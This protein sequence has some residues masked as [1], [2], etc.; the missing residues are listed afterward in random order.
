MTNALNSAPWPPVTC[1]QKGCS[2][3]SLF[4]S[5][6]PDTAL[7]D[8]NGTCGFGPNSNSRRESGA[9]FTLRDSGGQVN[10]VEE[11]EQAARH[12]NDI[13]SARNSSR[14]T[15][16]RRTTARSSTAY[17]QVLATPRKQSSMIDPR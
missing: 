4:F 6:P 12:A 5:L 8:A 14:K 15:S 3:G 9:L 17:R 10:T 13:I 1:Q 7:P 11:L 16:R 2:H